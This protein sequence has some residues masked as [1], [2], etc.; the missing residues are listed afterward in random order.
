MPTYRVE[1]EDGRLFD[2]EADSP[3]AVNSAVAQLMAQPQKPEQPQPRAA[4]PADD[5]ALRAMALGIYQPI[6]NLSQRLLRTDAGQ[7][8]NRAGVAIGLPDSNE[9]QRTRTDARRTNTRTGYQLAGNIVGTLPTMALPGGPVVQGAATGAVLSEEQSLG[10]VAQDAA[11]GGAFGKVGDV[12]TRSVAGAFAPR[13]SRAARMLN[14]AGV[15]LTLGQMVASGRSLAGRVAKGVEDR[16]AGL[17]IVGDLVNSAR[18]RGVEQYNRAIYRRALARAGLQLPDDVPAGRE[19]IKYVGDQLSAQ[20]QQILPRL[21]VRPD[22]RFA[23]G[24]QGATQSLSTVPDAIRTQY[25]SVLRR[26]FQTRGRGPQL[27]GDDL[28]AAEEVLTDFAAQYRGAADPDQR[29][30]AEAVGRVRDELRDL[31]V[32]QNGAAGSQLQR[33]NRAWSE[34]AVAERAA[35]TQGNASGVFTPKQY[36]A[37]SRMAD[38]TTRRRA[39]TRGT[40]DNQRMTDAAADIMPNTVPDSGTAGRV[41]LLAGGAGA[42]YGAA[43]GVLEP[44]TLA[45]LAAI[46]AP[47]TRAGQTATNWLY[48]ATRPQLVQRGAQLLRRSAPAIGGATAAIASDANSR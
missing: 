28:K 16:A 38:T 22:T 11:I 8:I 7:A 42:G 48:F 2:I 14:D 13:V 1:L 4:P 18:Q 39:T 23:A 25:Q 33:I 32:R 47:Y 20:Y 26:A 34:L 30:L 24:L 43:T 10:G 27:A 12:V 17:P 19:G 36:A 5:S 44:A 6:D 3:E 40:A 21:A 37:A 29:V 15:P 31:V 45:T 41:A 46:A 35:G 9:L